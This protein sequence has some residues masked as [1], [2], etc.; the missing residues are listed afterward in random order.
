MWRFKMSETPLYPTPPHHEIEVKKKSW[1]AR[2]VSEGDNEPSIRRV[3][4]GASILFAMAVA[5]AG[6]WVEIPGY[7]ETIT[8][9]IVSA[10]G[11]GVTA[12]RFA[13]R[14]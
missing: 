10:T 9:T 6:L 1:L 5:A 2:L 14:E 8:I 3:A 12:G 11:I 13:E 4:F 7:V